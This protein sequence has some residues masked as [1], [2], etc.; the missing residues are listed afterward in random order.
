MT[1]EQKKKMWGIIGGS[2]GVITITVFSIVFVSGQKASAIDYNTERIRGVKHAMEREL[3][4]MHEEVKDLKI[5]MR[6]G[7]RQIHEHL[8]R[9]DQNNRR[10]K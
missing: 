7:F 10:K 6:H 1:R 8:Q 4:E 9:V 2:I 5:E 3:N